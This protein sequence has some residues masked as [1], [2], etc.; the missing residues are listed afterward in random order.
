MIVSQV[1]Y[2]QIEVQHDLPD[3]EVV[4]VIRKM[5]KELEE[6]STAYRA[7]G[8]EDLVSEN[9]GQ[10]AVMRAYLPPEMSD[11]ELSKLVRAYIDANEDVFTSNPRAFTGKLVA[12]LKSQ[13]P[14]DRIVKIY[15]TMQ[16]QP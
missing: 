1:R 14:A 7:G 5:V 3:E 15:Q 9:A 13:V 2:K 11:E 6:A 10:I 4:V 12:A 16:I 8:R